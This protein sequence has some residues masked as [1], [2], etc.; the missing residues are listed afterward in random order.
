VAVVDIE[1]VS[2]PP[3]QPEGDAS[4]AAGRAGMPGPREVRPESWMP[5]GGTGEVMGTA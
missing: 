1:V 2:V 4:S 5:C 3:A